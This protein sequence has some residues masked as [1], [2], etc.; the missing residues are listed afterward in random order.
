MNDYN[1]TRSSNPILGLLIDSMLSAQRA[2]QMDD[3]GGL[4][5]NAGGPGFSF[6]GQG[7][8]GQNQNSGGADPLTSMILEWI[9][10]TQQAQRV[11]GGL[12]GP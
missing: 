9:K 2:Q 1:S 12:L 7:M 10:N 8:T 5:S 6:I 4:L 3:S 11:D